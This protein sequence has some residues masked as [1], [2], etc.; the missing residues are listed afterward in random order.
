MFYEFET[1][2][3]GKDDQKSVLNDFLALLTIYGKG[4]NAAILPSHPLT[5]MADYLKIL[6]NLASSTQQEYS[7]EQNTDYFINWNLNSTSMFNHQ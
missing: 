6:L 5:K 2:H 3:K 1:K 4:S 7:N